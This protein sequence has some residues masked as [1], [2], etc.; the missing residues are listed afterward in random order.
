MSDPITPILTVLFIFYILYLGY[1]NTVKPFVKKVI[2]HF[3]YK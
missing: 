2:N 3:K 1:K